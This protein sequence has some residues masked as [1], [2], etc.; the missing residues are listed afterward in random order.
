V[1]TGALNERG[2][3]NYR[4]A[5]LLLLATFVL[6]RIVYFASGLRFNATP[7][8]EFWQMV[9]PQL[10]RTDLWRSILYL[11]MQ[12]PG[13]NLAIGLILKLFP[14]HF[15]TALWVIQILCG[16][17]IAL[18]L[19]R[20]M[21]WMRVPLA[22]SLGLT[23][24][25]VISPAAVLYE[26]AAVYDYPICALLLAST[27]ALISFIEEPG[28]KR[29]LA[30]FG[31][32]AVLG[33]IRHLFHFLFL[34]LIAAIAL[35]LFPRARKAVVIG[36]VPM[37]AFIGAIHVKNGIL[38]GKYV[39]STWQ[40]MQIAR[41]TTDQ[42]TREEAA[43]L[44]ASGVVSPLARIETFS[45]L[46]VYLPYLNHP[47]EKTGIPVLDQA[48]TSTGHDN[49][50]VLTYIELQDRYG[51]DAKQV[52]L[53]KP[54]TFLRSLLSA[55]FCYFRPAAD[56]PYHFGA[57]AAPIE[58][59]ERI[60][61]GIF[62]GQF[63]R[64]DDHAAVKAVFHSGNIFGAVT[65]TGC[66]LVLLLP[67]VTGWAL[68]QLLTPR[69]RAEWTREQLIVTGYM[70]LT[71]CF[72]TAVV[73]ILS[74]QENNRYRFPLDPFFLVLTGMAITRLRPKTRPHREVD[75]QKIIAI[76]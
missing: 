28:Y 21:T 23:I 9:D 66:W 55:W 65:Y 37:L 14:V 49:Y 70:L 60:F 11:H 2:V 41:V 52:L 29:A 12:P 69:R 71:I 6:S 38:F 61:S 10:L 25:F 17:S 44:I 64:T 68:W 42:L 34:L 24:F 62:N 63:R 57:E 27:T 30:F 48:V 20:M 50:N 75:E 32:L 13:Y 67:I 58:P 36:A 1:S 4:Q 39:A 74:Y 47:L 56:L 7:I 16:I 53:H 31:W 76:G 22:L 54:V 8:D 35:V 43:S 19:L 33:F 15:A 73:N 46:K 18:N 45:P 59:W 3:L 26:D 72:V 40:G 51:V 5:R